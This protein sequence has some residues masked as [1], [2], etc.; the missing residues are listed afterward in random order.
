MVLGRSRPEGPAPNR[1][2][3]LRYQRTGVLGLFEAARHPLKAPS[4]L[5]QDP[6]DSPCAVVTVSQVVIQGG[7][8]VGLAGFF[9]LVELLHLEFVVSDGSPIISRGIHGE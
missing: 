6:L 9:H 7:K 3:N 1:S 4:S 2:L 8:A 5:P